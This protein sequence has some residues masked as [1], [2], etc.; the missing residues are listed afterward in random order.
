M[1]GK[2]SFLCIR[3]VR[4]KFILG[5]SIPGFAGPFPLT[6]HFLFIY[7]LDPTVI[8]HLL[9]VW[10]NNFNSI[11]V[12]LTSQHNQK[13]I[14]VLNFLEEK[15]NGGTMALND[16]AQRYGQTAL[17]PHPILDLKSQSSPSFSFRHTQAPKFGRKQIISMTRSSLGLQNKCVQ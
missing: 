11:P 7:C 5:D 10:E 15:G 1:K 13:T 14:T 12:N 4:N 16:S 2:C 8:T 3:E 9:H 6:T 17:I